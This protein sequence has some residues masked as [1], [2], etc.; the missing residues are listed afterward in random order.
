MVTWLACCLADRL[1]SALKC[2]VVTQRQVEV[3]KNNKS[4]SIHDVWS[5]Y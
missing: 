1:V 3:H 2:V 5:L 4:S